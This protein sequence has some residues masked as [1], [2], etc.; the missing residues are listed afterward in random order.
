MSSRTD[1][2]YERIT[3]DLLRGRWQ[4]GEMLSTYALSDELLI[5]RTPVREALKRIEADGLVEIIPQV[6]SRVVGSTTDTA[7]ELFALRSAIDGI[8]A[9][10]AAKHLDKD[11]LAELERLVDQL[12]D[13]VR[14]DDQAAYAELTSRFH[15]RIAEA[16]GMSRVAQSARAVWLPMRRHLSSLTS[17][18]EA[19][20]ESI[21]EHR[22]LLE[23]L[24]RRLPKRARAAAE[25]HARLCAVRAMASPQPATGAGLSHRALLYS[26]PDEFL[27]A[28]VPFLQEGLHNGELVLAVTTKA[29]IDALA[30]ALGSS[31]A[32][33]EYRDSE[34]WYLAPPRTLLAYERFLKYSDRD[35]VRILGAP[36]WGRLSPAA[37]R[38]WTRYESIINVEFALEPVTLMCAYDARALPGQ[39]V[40]D[41]HR[42]H[43]QLCIGGHCEPS[44]E[45]ISARALSRELDRQPLETPR[46]PVDQHVVTAD[47]RGVRKFALDQARRAGLARNHAADALLAVQEIAANVVVHGPGKGTLRS[48]VQDGELIYEVLDDGPGIADPLVA[49]LTPDLAAGAE[50][51]GLWLARLLSDLVEVRTTDDGFTVRLHLPLV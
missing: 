38:E 2:A 7:A 45:Y 12:E 20:S 35:R 34:D 46:A 40:G 26:S 50:P 15:M 9:E 19:L 49:H 30:S 3:E 36:T 31:S 1:Q 41:A 13:A 37:V 8:A 22:D 24:R 44:T 28:A 18:S 43:P 5:S 21:A 27:Q 51:G 48:W 17:A 16:S 11:A 47:Q 39:T 6:G 33:V 32:D 4:G 14:Q 10:A 42:T 25:R 23:A 29:N